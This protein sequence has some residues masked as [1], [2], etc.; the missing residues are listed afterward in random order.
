MRVGIAL[1]LLAGACRTGEARFVVRLVAEDCS[2]A[3]ECFDDALL[4]FYGWSD[5]ATCQE[6]HG[7]TIAGIAA[8]C[9]EFDKAASKECLK[10]LSGRSCVDSGPS[11]ARPDICDTVFSVCE[12]GSFSETEALSASES[13]L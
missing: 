3:L 4:N 12:G 9:D 5:R 8:S 7:P 2:Y 10:A 13:E 6:T 1:M 11:M